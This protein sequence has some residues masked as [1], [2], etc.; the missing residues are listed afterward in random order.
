LRIV[1]LRSKLSLGNRD[2]KLAAHAGA[3]ALL[4]L[5]AAA[6]AQE[7]DPRAAQAAF[8]RARVALLPWSWDP[9]SGRCDEIV[10]RFCYRHESGVDR[11]P[12]PEPAGVAGARDSLLVVLDA[13]AKRDPADGWVVGQRVRYRIEAGR[14]AEAVAVAMA[15]GAEPWWCAALEG[16]SRHAAGDFA[17]AELAFDLALTTMPVA[18][19]ERWTDLEPILDAVSRRIWRG[20]APGA[21][22]AFAR[23]LWWVAD[24]LWSVP[25]NERRTEHLSRHVWDGMQD[26]AASAYDVAW[27]ADLRAL[28]VRYGWPA[29]WERV[30]GDLGRL[31]GGGRPGVVAHDPPGAKRFVPSLAAIADPAVADASEWALDH[32]S[33]PATY[34][35][36]YARRF[37]SLE[38]QIARFRRQHG[39]IVAIGWAPPDSLAADSRSLALTALAS[40]GP[41]RPFVADSV[42]VSAEGGS[43]AIAVPW[44]RAVLGVEVRG[45]ALAGRWR[46][47]VE[48]PAA[49]TR[50]PAISDLLLLA[51]PAVLPASLA[52]AIP[53]ARGSSHAAPGERLGV[54]WEAYPPE[55]A[56]EGPVAIALAIRDQEGE[57]GALRWSETFPAGER[58]VP[59]AVALRIPVLRPGDYVLQVEIVWP[60]AGAR[61][62]Q[63]AFTIAP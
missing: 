7:S 42:R 5:P 49:A 12:P 16:A 28:L 63:R 36:S 40:E 31:G 30:R 24:P 52:E 61:R 22:E 11:P 48:L 59:R 51:S 34:A 41:D 2:L 17:A 29:W 54:F 62:A 19:R 8:E 56:A 15:C 6:A 21:R 35:P 33:P 50:G 57:P 38:P 45:A 10:G 44:P 14:A 25:G 18:E 26:G 4:A 9:G 32:P 60:R 27:G 1:S 3:I 13:A 53:L 37:V 43:L 58:V 47:G 46:A 55:G 20:L 23:R 39:A